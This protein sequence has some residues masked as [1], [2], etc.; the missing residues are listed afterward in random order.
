VTIHTTPHHTASNTYLS[1]AGCHDCAR[2]R[3]AHDQPRHLCWQSSAWA[4]N[5]RKC[6]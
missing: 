5:K 1:R 4:T 3:R 6:G 2:V